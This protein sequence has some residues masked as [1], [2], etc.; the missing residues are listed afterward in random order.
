MNQ[1]IRYYNQNRKKIWGIVIIIASAILLLQLVNYFYKVE[2][3]K[4][5]EG[6]NQTRKEISSINTNTTKVIDNQS[7]VTGKQIAENDL[8]TATNI[9]D[10]FFSYCNGKEIEKAYDLLTEDC[11]TEMYKNLEVFEQAYYN[12]VFEGE[13]KTASIENWYG[14]TYKV[15][16]MGNMLATGKKE[17]NQKQDYITIVKENNENKLNINGYIGKKGINKTTEKNNIKVE[18]VNRNT[19]KDYETYTVRITNNTGNTILLDSR[20]DAKTL[21]IQDNK[22]VR[23]SSYSHELTEPMMTITPDNTK[24]ITIKFYSAFISSKKIEEIVFSE[25]VLFNG[26]LTEKIEIRVDI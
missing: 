21:Y 23:Y 3:Q 11:K 2:N 12:N 19:Y 20:S 16:I 13:P 25:V 10:T 18:I 1:L 24:E 4:R 6:G 5:L 26:Q 9:I 14:D 22:N 15:K 8:E 7:V 17:E